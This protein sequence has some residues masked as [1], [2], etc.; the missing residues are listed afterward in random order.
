MFLGGRVD[1]WMEQ[2][3]CDLHTTRSEVCRHE[4]DKQAR[5][6]EV[7]ISRSVP[8][9]FDQEVQIPTWRSGADQV[10]AR[11]L[12]SS[13]MEGSTLSLR[14][15][16]GEHLHIAAHQIDCSVDLMY[17]RAQPRWHIGVKYHR[18]AGGKRSAR[19]CPPSTLRCF[20]RSQA[21]A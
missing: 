14:N 5:R 4:G 9:G 21:T 2:G 18:N 17:R 8:V 1:G 6:G 13:C 15:E 12:S 7:G 16:T 11:M 20:C 10:S 19:V 3:R